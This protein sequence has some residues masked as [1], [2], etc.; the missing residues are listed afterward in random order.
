MQV[1]DLKQEQE[2]KEVGTL[3]V[4]NSSQLDAELKLD[5]KQCGERVKK[6]QEDALKWKGQVSRMHSSNLWSDRW[7]NS[8]HRS[9]K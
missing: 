8:R 5:Q 7:M 9:S 1:N 4:P 2:Q 6:W 3:L